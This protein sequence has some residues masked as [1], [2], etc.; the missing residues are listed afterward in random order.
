MPGSGGKV[1]AG[2][3]YWMTD[4]ELRQALEMM[5]GLG[6]KKS[7]ADI[8]AEVDKDM[9]NDPRL[10]LL[11]INCGDETGHLN[12]MPGNGSKYAD[13]PFGPKT[14][15]ILATNEGKPGDFG[16]M[17]G[18]T[19]PGGKRESYGV[20]GS[21]TLDVKKFDKTGIAGTF[22]LTAE[23]LFKGG[24]AITIDGDFDYGCAGQSVCAR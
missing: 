14:Y 12:F 1:M 11:L 9:K 10:M 22:H 24:D 21:G 18:F 3:D 5:A 23:K 7:D 13:V 6:A 15:K 16:A 8:A 17:V 2:T 4:G 20:T 19:P